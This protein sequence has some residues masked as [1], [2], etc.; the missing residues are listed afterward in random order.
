MINKKKTKQ[1]TVTRLIKQKQSGK[2]VAQSSQ[3][4]TLNAHTL[5]YVNFNFLSFPLNDQLI[6]NTDKPDKAKSTHK[7]E[8]QAEF[9]LETQANRNTLSLSLP[10][11]NQSM[12]VAFLQLLENA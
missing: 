5:A 1:K 12:S 6:K 3:I 9:I 7:T 8:A 11:N 2:I 10:V 4:H